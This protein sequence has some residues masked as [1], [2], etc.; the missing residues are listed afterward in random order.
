MSDAFDMAARLASRICHDLI[1]P[2]GAIGN[3][4]EL[5]AMSGTARSP[6][7]QLVADSV[8]NAEARIKFFRIAFGQADDSQ[9]VSAREI[10]ATLG[11][12]Y[13]ASRVEVDWPASEPVPRAELRAVFL[14][15]MCLETEL[16][17]GGRIEVSGGPGGWQL[18]ARAERTRGEEAA[19]AA[20]FTG[21]SA[22][23]SPAMLHFA[24]L[25]AA[26]AACGRRLRVVREER[27]LRMSL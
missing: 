2:I 17:F 25:P 19:W 18:V 22:A 16:A 12:Y 9:V 14:A 26:L 10:G 7:F 24:M 13:A 11:D 8:K 5:L 3:G 6:E 15:L 23:L 20:L 1:S 21:D 27:E 4:V